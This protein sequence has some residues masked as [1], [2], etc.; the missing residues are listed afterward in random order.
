MLMV[1]S[2]GHHNYRSPMDMQGFIFE[3]LKPRQLDDE[4][5]TD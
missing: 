2:R 4:L 3:A 1:V 5:I